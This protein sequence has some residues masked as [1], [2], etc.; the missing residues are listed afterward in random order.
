[1]KCL[2]RRAFMVKMCI[3]SVFRRRWSPIFA[4]AIS[5]GSIGITVGRGTASSSSL[6]VDDDDD[7]DKEEDSEQ[8]SST[9]MMATTTG[10]WFGVMT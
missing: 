10:H 7:D 3:A 1:M 9:F 2:S 4:Y 5:I 8:L 6:L